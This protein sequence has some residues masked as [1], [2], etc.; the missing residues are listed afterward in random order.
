M[1]QVIERG[2][3]LSLGKIAGRAEDDHDAGRGSVGCNLN[4]GIILHLSF[5]IRHLSSW[6]SPEQ[7]KTAFI[8]HQQ[9]RPPRVPGDA[10]GKW[11]MKNET[12][13]FLRAR[14]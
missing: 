8:C 2:N 10:Q 12:W 6:H 5:S 1:L 3:Q 7:F 14:L 11:Q 13:L 4:D 9:L